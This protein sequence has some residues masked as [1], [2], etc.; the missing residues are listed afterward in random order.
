MAKICRP[1]VEYRDIISS[2][3]ITI[4]NYSPPKKTMKRFIRIFK[5]IERF[6]IAKQKWLRKFLALKNGIPSHDPSDGCSR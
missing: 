4:N 5:K 1:I 2:S 6:G 3:G